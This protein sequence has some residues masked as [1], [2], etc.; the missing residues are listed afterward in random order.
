[1]TISSAQRIA[2]LSL[3]GLDRIGFGQVDAQ[4]A[5][6]ARVVL[7][8]YAI[9]ADRLA[10]GG[11]TLW[12]RSGCELVLESERLEWVNRGG[13]TEQLLITRETAVDLFTVAAQHAGTHGIPLSLDTVR[14]APSKA[15]A[16]AIDFSLTKA[17]AEEKAS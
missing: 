5:V 15:L 4:A 12:L 8:T 14:L 7:A 3:A 9:V 16:E 2:T 1:V 13:D 10:F 6:A 11:P 17:T